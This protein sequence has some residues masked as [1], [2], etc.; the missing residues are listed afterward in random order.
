LQA[1]QVIADLRPFKVRPDIPYAAPHEDKKQ[2]GDEKDLAGRDGYSLLF[3]PLVPHPDT[4]FG[5]SFSLNL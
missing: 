3:G 5:I 4:C 1:A 2:E